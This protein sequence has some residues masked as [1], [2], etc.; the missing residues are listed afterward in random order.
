MNQGQTAA[1]SW[2][3]KVKKW[4]QNVENNRR[5]RGYDLRSAVSYA[6]QS[7]PSNWLLKFTAE[8]AKELA[9]K[10]VRWAIGDAAKSLGISLSDVELD[11]LAELAVA[12][13]AS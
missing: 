9:V 12:G 10:V 1:V 5:V 2:R 3:I 8:V 6:Q 13:I 4:L 7:F 11:L